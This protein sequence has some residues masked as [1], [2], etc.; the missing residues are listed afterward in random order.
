V[1]GQQLIGGAA[2]AARRGAIAGLL[3]MIVAAPAIAVLGHR[4]G[5]QPLVERSGSMAPAIVTGDLVL[6]RRQRAEEMRRGEVITFA[7]PHVRGRTLTHR[8]LAVRADGWRLA[9]TT[10]GDASAAAEHWTVARDGTVG[11]LQRTI[12]LPRGVSVLLDR[13]HA[14]G[15]AMLALSLLACGLT[16][17]AIWRR[18][19]PPCALP[20]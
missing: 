2:R 4:A 14:R 8:V 20:R 1:D 3:T 6:V 13:S 16:L 15:M 5:W 19:A 11:R 18:P 9:V 12:A 17:W 7:D 10:R